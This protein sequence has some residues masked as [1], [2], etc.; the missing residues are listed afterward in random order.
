MKEDSL[1]LLLASGMLTAV[2]AVVGLIVV[3]FLG[4][5]LLHVVDSIEDL[6][7]E[8]QQQ[9]VTLV[10]ILR[11]AVN[12][13][14]VI[15]ALLMLLGTFGVDVTPL[16][17]SVGVAGL[18]VSLGA[19]SLIKDLI[20]GFLIVAENQYGVGDFIEV[21]DVSGIVEQLTL[22]A[23]YLRGADGRL[24][25]VPNGEVRVVA[26]LT[27]D[28]SRAVVDLAIAYEQDLDRVL[29]ILKE[30]A[31][32]FAQDP[33]FAPQIL[34]PPTVLGPLTLAEWAI[35][36]KVLVKT[37]PGDQWA[38]ARELKKQ[39]LA[40]CEREGIVLPYP[41]R[42]VWLRSTDSTIS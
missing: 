11:W 5:F 17:A 27:K 7:E 3:K 38:V 34:E 40:V 28:W 30:T 1:S 25:I 10:R 6:H 26:N 31:E 15:S 21:G 16:L 20:G 24:H 41:R 8:R 13:L 33:E 12:L 4:K 23:T 18:A 2:L 22:R 32:A 14:I 42:E 19:Q 39:L 35:N 36:V 37:L 9:L 29:R